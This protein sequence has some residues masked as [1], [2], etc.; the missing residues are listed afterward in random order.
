[1]K[2]LLF[3]TLLLWGRPGYAQ[4]VSHRDRVYTADQI[5]NT[6]SVIDPVDN[7]LLGQI[8]LGKPQPDILTPL[9]RGQ[10]LVHGLGL[11][12]DHRTLAVVSVGSNSVTFIDPATNAIKGSVYVGRAPHEPTFRPDG[13]EVWVTVRGEDYVSVI[14]VAT[15]R[16]TRRIQ[17]AN[18]PGMVAF[19]PDNKRAFVCSSFSPEL[20]V[21]DAATYA[22]IKH[23]PVA[24]PFSPNIFATKDGSQVWFTHKDVGKV[25]VLDIKTLSI[26]QVLDTG[27]ITNHVTTLDT[28]LGKVAYVSVGGENVVK[29]FSR[30]PGFR[31]LAT[32]P[33]G[34]LPHGIWASGDASRVY[35]NLEN[36][37]SVVAI[38]TA[39]NQVL[40]KVKVG[41][42][43][44]ALV[45]VP[46]AVPAGATGLTNLGRQLVDQ[47][48]VVRELKAVGGG[49][50]AGSLVSRSEGLVDLASFSL[51]HLQPDTEYDI[52]LSRATQAPY[53]RD[54]PLLTVRT[55]AKGGAM[56]QTLGPVQAVPNT[57]QAS[58]GKPYQRVVVAPKGAGSA[59]VLVS[60]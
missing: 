25:S 36:A 13:K 50:A 20:T 29:V 41:Q 44:M 38:S 21:V 27:P 15:L 43:P 19:S 26:A 28:K 3:G 47:P 11:A 59:P 57:D 18:G 52:Y 5:S 22:V 1:M 32:I 6:V 8:I 35:V 39:T 53:S 45:Y 34:A 9:Y 7:K 55:D 24:S 54:Y 37:D 48:T 12:P 14:D 56:A 31:Q 60:W 30:E 46:N 49:A 10:A 42:A 17:V 23:V 33:V 16:E 40:G 4:T 2:Y 58:G 51:M